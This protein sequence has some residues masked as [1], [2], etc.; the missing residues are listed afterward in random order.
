MRGLDA[1]LAQPPLCLFGVTAPDQLLAGQVH[2]R[3]GAVQ[4]LVPIAAL[5]RTV[6]DRACR[7]TQRA[8]RG[9]GAARQDAHLVAALG[10]RAH[11]V[12]SN[13]PRSSGNNDA[14][15]GAH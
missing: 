5:E 1:A 6:D 12:S 7:S 3:V 11:Q 4:C 2:D 14:F 8:L 13:E 15:H 10:Q 9:L